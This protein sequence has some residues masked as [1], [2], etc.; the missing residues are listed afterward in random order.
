MV[1]E[2][3]KDTEF[4]MKPLKS[5]TKADLH[6]VKDLLDTAVANDDRCLGLT[7]NQIGYD[8]RIIVVKMD[9]KYIPFINPVILQKSK[10]TYIAEEGC[11]SLDGARE[12]KRHQS[13][14]LLWTDVNFK[15]H[16]SAFHGLAA[17]IIQHEVDHCNGKL[18]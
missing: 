17:E 13:I 8:K 16:K 2:I 15:S 9:D 5:A 11:L 7:A 1:K 18:I 12:V 3:V 4:L 6:I 14:M 10:A